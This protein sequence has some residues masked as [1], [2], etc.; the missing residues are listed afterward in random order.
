MSRAA[1]RSAGAGGELVL[2]LEL[3]RR[4]DLGALRSSAVRRGLAREVEAVLEHLAH[5]P[6]RAVRAEV[7]ASVEHLARLGGA[8]TEAVVDYEVT[9]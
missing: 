7:G 8:G 9:L 1:P 2:R 3:V 4:K 6:R 5:S